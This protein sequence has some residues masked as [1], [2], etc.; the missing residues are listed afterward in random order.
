M[1]DDREGSSGTEFGFELE[2]REDVDKGHPTN[3]RAGTR[4]TATVLDED[5]LAREAQNAESQYGNALTN[6]KDREE[7]FRRLKNQLEGQAGDENQPVNRFLADA[8]ATGLADVDNEWEVVSSDYLEEDGEPIEFADEDQELLDYF[9]KNSGAIE[10]LSEQVTQFTGLL[11]SVSEKEKERINEIES[12]LEE[13]E[14]KRDEAIEEAQEEKENEVDNL[15]DQVANMAT[16]DLDT[17]EYGEPNDMWEEEWSDIS[18]GFNATVEE[19]EARYDDREEELEQER[20]EIQRDAEEQR[21]TLRSQKQSLVSARADRLDEIEEVHV[22]F[23][24]DVIEYVEEQAEG[25][26]DLFIT[27]SSLQNMRDSHQ[28]E[29]VAE[30]LPGSAELSQDQQGISQDINSAANALATRALT[31]IDYLE[32]AVTDYAAVAETLPGIL[33]EQAPRV[34]ERL[35]TV[36]SEYEGLALEVEGDEYGIEGLERRVQSHVEEITD[37]EYDAV[38]E[39]REHVES[40]AR[41]P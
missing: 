31:R 14:R 11:S 8:E 38:D 15:Q 28:N 30:A 10:N 25:L 39:F 34:G 36:V 21:S 23:S 40:M 3:R 32:D 13:A 33:E 2:G 26:E 22:E 7:R 6:Q 37:S 20:A 27:L 12:Q 35:E 41:M 1:S 16:S 5:E 17:S 18:G 9:M 19:A 24:N 4:A 29:S